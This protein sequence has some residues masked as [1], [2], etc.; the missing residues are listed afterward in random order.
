MSNEFFQLLGG[1][2][3]GSLCTGVLLSAK[4]DRALNGWARAENRIESLEKEL[5][6]LRERDELELLRDKQE[7]DWE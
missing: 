3:L 4:L 5:E 6:E 1:A 2:M 7:R